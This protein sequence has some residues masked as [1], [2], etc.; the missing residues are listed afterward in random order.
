MKF[1]GTPLE[2]TT[3]SLHHL[4]KLIFRLYYL[5]HQPSECGTLLT[6]VSKILLFKHYYFPKLQVPK[7]FA[8]GNKYLS[9]LHA[10]IRYN[11]SN[12]NI[13]LYI[14]HLCD[15]PLC[16]WCNE[17]EDGEHFFFYCNNHRNERCAFFEIARYFQPLN[18]K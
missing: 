3:T 2:I 16:N 8:F 9:V 7:Y 12:L 6:K 5:Y 17:I 14:N 11:C 13:D 18:I 10:R 4:L 1:R 15:N